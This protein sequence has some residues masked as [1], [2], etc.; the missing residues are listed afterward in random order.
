MKLCTIIEDGKYRATI[1]TKMPD[2]DE[3]VMIDIARAVDVLSKAHSQ[4]R[5][6]WITP[7]KSPWGTFT[8]PKEMLE[9]VKY[10]KDAVRALYDLE[11]ILWQLGRSADMARAE[12]A[13]LDPENITWQA[14]IPEPAAYFYHHNNAPSVLTEQFTEYGRRKV[15]HPR[16]RPVNTIIGEGEPIFANKD[17]YVKSDMEFGFVIGPDARLVGIDEAMDYVFGYTVCCD[18]RTKNY[19]EY[20][21]EACGDK[22]HHGHRVASAQMCKASDGCGPIGPYIVTADEVGNPHDLLG[23]VYFNEIKRARSYTGSYLD[24][25]PELVSWF[26]RIK[27]LE[28][29]TLIAMGACGFDGYGVEGEYRKPGQNIVTIEFERVGKLSLP[30]IYPDEEQALERGDQSPYLHRRKK[31]GLPSIDEP[32]LSSKNI[33]QKTRSLWSLYNSLSKEDADHVPQPYMYPPSTVASAD[34]E[35]ILPE[36][37]NVVRVAVQLGAV[38]GPK[39]Q[40]RPKI[41]QVRQHLLGFVPVVSLQDVRVAEKYIKKEDSSKQC[42]ESSGF[43]AMFQSFYGDGFFRVGKVVPVE[44]CKSI[45]DSAITLSIEGLGE[46]VANTADYN[47]TIEKMIEWITKGVTCLPGDIFCLGPSAATLEIP[48]EE[49]SSRIISASIENVG[50]IE[51]KIKDNRDPDL[52]DWIGLRI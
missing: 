19:N 35:I 5:L 48:A 52:P 9:I 20:Y 38:I 17:H 25:I 4:N 40:Y 41:D 32:D 7:W 49:F 21:A 47:T 29:G 37:S 45:E 13:L 51:T 23:H 34:D 18:T 28:A 39:P 24:R 50:K 2:S 1:L 46:A 42:H 15:P 12:C 14:P 16:T 36:Q 3:E 27:T 6:P 26:S 8:A 22:A 31:L 11:N 30:V 10:G 33:P 43:F 44:N